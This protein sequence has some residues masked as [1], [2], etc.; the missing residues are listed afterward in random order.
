MS[1][2]EDQSF[3]LYGLSAYEVQYWT[4]SAWATVPGGGVTG[5]NKVWR[6]VTFPAV[7]TAKIRVVVNA[8][9]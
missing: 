2:G 6:K 5:N 4:G 9:L 8:G 1:K 7:T 3:T